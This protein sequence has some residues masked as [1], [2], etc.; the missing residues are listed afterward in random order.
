MNLDRASLEAARKSFY[1]FLHAYFNTEPTDRPTICIPRQTDDDDIVV[2]DFFDAVE[3]H[4]VGQSVPSTDTQSLIDM[5]NAINKYHEGCGSDPV[6]LDKYVDE[7]RTFGFKALDTLQRQAATNFEESVKRAALLYGVSEDNAR[8][9]IV[10]M[11]T[12]L[13]RI[14]E[15]AG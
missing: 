8:Q 2:A 10:G 3:K 1:R 11:R 12:A 6:I 14:D 7:L 13:D 9:V 4:L 15:D 5:F